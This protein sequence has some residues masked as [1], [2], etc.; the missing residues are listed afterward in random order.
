M[1]PPSKG[2][3][4]RWPSLHTSRLLIRAYTAGDY[5][6]YLA[7]LNGN[8]DTP[9][10]EMAI[11]GWLDEAAFVKRVEKFEALGRNGHQFVFGMFE[12]SSQNLLGQLDLFEINRQFAWFNFGCQ[13]RESFRKQGY[14][15]EGCLAMI[16]AAITHRGI[17]RIEAGIDPENRNALAL[18]KT[19]GLDFEGTRRHFFPG[20]S[21]GHI[22]VYATNAVDW[23]LKAE[24]RFGNDEDFRYELS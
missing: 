22:Q 14:A 24:K 5:V 9:A 16:D 4:G 1:N 2:I 12:A 10:S 15:K 20:H 21:E 19:L 3:P 7:G 23:K 8:R 13:I 18:V 6:H 11:D 17:H